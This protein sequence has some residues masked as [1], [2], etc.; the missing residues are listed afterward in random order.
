[1]FQFRGLSDD[2]WA[3]TQPDQPDVVGAATESGVNVFSSVGSAFKNLFA[4]SA[5]VVTTQAQPGTTPGTKVTTVAP[6]PKPWY[7]TPI[8]MLAIAGGLFAGWKYGLPKLRG[9]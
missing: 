8:G 5:A 9:K 3:N 4:P 1:M 7:K 2:P 6:L